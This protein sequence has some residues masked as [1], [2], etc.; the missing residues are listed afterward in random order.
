VGSWVNVGT[1]RASVFEQVGV[2]G[3]VLALAG[4]Q[5]LSSSGQY[6]VADLTHRLPDTGG[7][8]KALIAVSNMGSVISSRC[9]GCWLPAVEAT[10]ITTRAGPHF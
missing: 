10:S 9:D 4:P 2:P 6:A 5:F 3:S 8:V 1:R 7:S